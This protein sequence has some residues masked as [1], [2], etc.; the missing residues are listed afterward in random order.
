[1]SQS[2]KVKFKFSPVVLGRRRKGGTMRS[3]HR[4]QHFIAV[5]TAFAKKRSNLLQQ[6]VSPCY[7]RRRGA[8][9]RPGERAS[10]EPPASNPSSG[11]TY[12]HA[13]EPPVSLA[14]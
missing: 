8:E 5:A 11:S 12:R 3:R 6:V 13:I 14:Q 2:S 4:T 7:I 9:H 1:M 10:G